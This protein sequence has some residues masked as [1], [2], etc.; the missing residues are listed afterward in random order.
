MST[1]DP[2]PL[3]QHIAEHHGG[4]V[5]AFTKHHGLKSRQTVYNWIGE[6]ATWWNDDVWVNK[7]L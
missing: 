6:G 7:K 3:V 4:S 2:V 1:C 5:A